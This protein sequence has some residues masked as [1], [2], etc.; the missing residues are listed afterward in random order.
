MMHLRSWGFDATSGT[1]SLTALGE[2]PER[3]GA[4]AELAEA[5]MARVLFLPAYPGITPARRGRLA[6]ALAV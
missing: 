6:E 3:P 4:R 2:V 1:S 5:T